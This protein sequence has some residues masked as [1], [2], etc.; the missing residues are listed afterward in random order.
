MN[1]REALE[2]RLSHGFP[3]RQGT[4]L[5]DSL[6]SY[7]VITGLELRDQGLMLNNMFI[8]VHGPERRAVSEHQLLYPACNTEQVR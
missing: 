4:Q 3:L 6:L 2:L 8:L 7:S 1:T 5:C